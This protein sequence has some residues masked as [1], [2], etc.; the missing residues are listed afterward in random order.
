MN[1]YLMDATP[2]RTVVLDTFVSHIWVDR[3]DEHGDF[4]L[5]VVA[6]IDNIMLFQNA[7]YLSIDESDHVMKIESIKLDSDVENGDTLSIQG[8]SLEV[9]LFYRIVWDQT[10]LNGNLQTEIHRLLNENA[11]ASANPSRNIANLQLQVSVDPAI[12]GLTVKSQYTGDY[13]YDVISSICKAANIGFKITLDS[14]NH[15]VFLLYAGLDR[16][17]DQTDNEYVVFSPNFEN[18]ISSNYVISDINLKT[19]ALVAGEGEGTARLTTV[20]D[21]YSATDLDRRELYV[22]ARDLSKTTAGGTLPDVDYLAE[23]AQRGQEKL[24][25]NIVIDHF[26]GEVDTTVMYTYGADFSMGDI[27]QII[28][29]YGQGGRSRI[30]EFIISEDL[31][32]GITTHP[33]FQS[34]D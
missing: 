3:Y 17:Y 2:K 18:L 1:I 4:E 33:T 10:L 22:D 34:L 31:T 9:I 15:F 28:N 23:L 30:T 6:S 12:T 13:L 5:H 11:I 7:S 25:E 24:A 32:G 27:V 8:R 21:P 19:V 26:E 14:A 20:V 16:S 29:Q